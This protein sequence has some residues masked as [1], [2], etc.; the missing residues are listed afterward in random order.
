VFHAGSGSRFL[1]CVS[2]GARGSIFSHVILPRLLNKVVDRFYIF[3]R[4]VGHAS[5]QL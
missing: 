2:D 1:L 5:A 4:A 3:D